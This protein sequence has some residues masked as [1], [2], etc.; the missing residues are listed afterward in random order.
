[1]QTMVRAV[2]WM[3]EYRMFLSLGAIRW[4]IAWRF[5]NVIARPGYARLVKL[6]VRLR[7]KSVKLRPDDAPEWL[8]ALGGPRCQFRLN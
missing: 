3:V 5:W 2:F 4:W 6:E 7:G 1:V 8:R